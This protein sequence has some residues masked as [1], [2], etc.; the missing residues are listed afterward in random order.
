MLAYNRVHSKDAAAKG[1]ICQKKNHEGGVQKRVSG[2]CTLTDFCSRPQTSIISEFGVN[3]LF[4]EQGTVSCL[5]YSFKL[6][7]SLSVQVYNLGTGTGYSVLQMVKAMEK[8]SGR[9][10]SI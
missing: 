10:V 4:S 8:A 2:Q 6:F 3:V 7:L 5:W 9:E 1:T